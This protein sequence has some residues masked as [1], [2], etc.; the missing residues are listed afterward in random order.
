MKPPSNNRPTVWNTAANRANF[1]PDV[2]MVQTECLPDNFGATS[3]DL[4]IDHTASADGGC[5]VD[6]WKLSLEKSELNIGFSQHLIGYALKF[7][8]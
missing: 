1:P 5:H 7:A 4:H 2:C 3:R 6:L 8:Y